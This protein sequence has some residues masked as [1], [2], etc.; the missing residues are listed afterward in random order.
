MSSV[1]PESPGTYAPLFRSGHGTGITH[2]TVVKS[3][4][5]KRQRR[6]LVRTEGGDV[7]PGCVAV[8]DSAMDGGGWPPGTRV[9]IALTDDGSTVVLGAVSASNAKFGDETPPHDEAEEHPGAVGEGDRVIESNGIRL[10][11]GKD[12]NDLLIEVPGILRIAAGSIRFSR[13]GS[14]GDHVVLWEPFVK[15]A[16]ALVDRVNKNTEQLMNISPGVATAYEASLATAPKAV[17]VN[18]WIAEVSALGDVG[19]P[20]EELAADSIV[21][22]PREP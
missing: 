22:P 20:D 3:T 12:P 13:S 6:Y 2:A 16:E 8:S 1:R 21:V 10:V 17:P 18:A 4:T 7:I 9:V 11:F 19:A 14:T 15:W 5:V